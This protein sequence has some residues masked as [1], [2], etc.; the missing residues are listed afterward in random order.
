M[1]L[2]SFLTL[3]PATFLMGL[4]FPIGLRL[5]VGEG[6]AGSRTGR[7]YAWNVCGSILG[8]LA[9]GFVLLP[10]L[11]SRGSV[12]LLAER[13]PALRDLAGGRAARRVATPR[14]GLGRAAGTCAFAL[15]AVRRAGAV[16]HRAGAPP[17][18]RA[19]AVVRRRDRRPR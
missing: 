3:F 12:L 4:A 2:A 19:P 13:L 8:A 17:S 15:A 16:R 18:G 14:M 5:Y 9:G 6:A 7:F 11:G 10:T 1:L